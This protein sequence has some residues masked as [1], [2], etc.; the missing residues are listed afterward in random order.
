M[1]VL[2]RVNQL[3]KDLRNEASEQT[4]M[5]IKK[6]SITVADVAQ[7]AKV[8]KATAARVLGGYGVA[9]EKTRKAVT[10][11]AT[12][13][14]YQS[15]ELARSM[16]TGRTGLI[17]VIVGDIENA[18]FSRA[19][20]G[21]SDAANAAGLNVI[22]TNSNEDIEQEREMVGVLLRQRVAGM[23]IA[24][25]DARYTEHIEAAISSGTPVVTLDRILVGL[26]ADSVC[27][28]D[29]GAAK[30]IMQHLHDL[31]HQN[32][33]YVTASEI[34][35]EQLIALNDIRITAVRHRIE[36]FVCAS[37]A[38][39]IKDP[40]S[41]VFANAVSEENARRIIDV[42]LLRRPKIT[43]ILASD[44]LVGAALYRALKECGV[45]LPSDLSLVSWFDADWTR[46]TT[47]QISVIDQP[48][49]VFGQKAMERLNAR[50]NGDRSDIS[51]LMI[52]TPLIDRGSIAQRKA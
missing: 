19:V 8:S 48:T 39:C 11:A 7:A 2:I 24:P 16:S 15:N 41:L 20:R 34:N 37:E 21:I 27:G 35:G 12:L 14:G 5:S 10:E 40:Y 6:T 32:I 51:H 13:L 25:T 26:S 23:I 33:A 4:H 28:D 29:K 42:I 52:P 17:G 49:Y 9:S 44:S 47:P 46:V 36:A 18:F 43:A 31:G 45:E 3:D 22:I 30:G 50:I 1:K 38:A